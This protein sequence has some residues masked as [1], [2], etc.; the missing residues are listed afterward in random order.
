MLHA[1]WSV[2]VPGLIDARPVHDAAARGCRPRTGSPSPRAAGALIVGGVFGCPRVVARP[3]LSRG[4]DDERVVG[5]LQVVELLQ[6]AADGLVQALDH[7]GV[8]RVAL[9]AG[10]SASPGTSSITSCFARSGVWTA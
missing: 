6:H 8:D 3:P 9:L 2:V 4:E 7:R 10:P 1:T 5:Q